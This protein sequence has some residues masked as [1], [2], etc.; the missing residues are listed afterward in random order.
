MPTTMSYKGKA[1]VWAVLGVLT[2]VISYLSFRG[3]FAA[4]LLIGFANLLHC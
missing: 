3:Y 1:F 4:D 2:A